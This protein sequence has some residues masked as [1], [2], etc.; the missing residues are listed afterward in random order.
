MSQINKDVML[1]IG[2][3][4]LKI[5]PGHDLL[6]SSLLVVPQSSFQSGMDPA[7]LWIAGVKIYYS[8]KIH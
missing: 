3:E 5:F 1:Q 4:T 8:L 7:T 6:A 2:W